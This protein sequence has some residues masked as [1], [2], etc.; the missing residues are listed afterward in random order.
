MFSKKKCEYVFFKKHQ[1]VVASNET[2][3]LVITT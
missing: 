2:P 3:E 1:F